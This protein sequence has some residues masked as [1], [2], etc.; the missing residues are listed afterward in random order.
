MRHRR[1]PAFDGRV[2][3]TG[4]MPAT[5]PV[6]MPP[7]IAGRTAATARR[8]AGAV[9]DR[10]EAVAVTDAFGRRPGGHDA[11]GKAAAG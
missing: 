4:A 6:A 11:A 3:I 7:A 1:R 2:D 8:Y 10:H 9:R 5:S